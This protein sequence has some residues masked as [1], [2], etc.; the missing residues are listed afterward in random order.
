MRSRNTSMSR[1][2]AAA[3]SLCCL[4]LTGTAHAAVSFLSGTT[5][6]TSATLS[7]PVAVASATQTITLKSTTAAYKVYV[8]SSSTA[9]KITAPATGACGIVSTSTVTVAANASCNFNVSYTPT[10]SAAASATITAYVSATTTGTATAQTPTLAL[11]GNS[12][13]IALRNG[14]TAIT[15]YAFPSVAAGSTSTLAVT[16]ANLSTTTALSGVTVTA[17]GTGFTQSSTCATTLAASGTCVSNIT[18]APSAA[19]AFTGTLTVAATNSA[20]STVSLTGTGSTPVPAW[21]TTNTLGTG[22]AMFM[23]GPPMR[24][25]TTTGVPGCNSPTGGFVHTTQGGD[26]CAFASANY[27][28]SYD[29]SQTGTAY[30]DYY[31]YQASAGAAYNKATDYFGYSVLAPYA[32]AN[33]AIVPV[34]IANSAAMLIRLGNQ[35]TPT[36]TNG[37]ANVFSVTVKNQAID[38]SWPAVN[39]AACSVDVVLL[40][41]ATGTANGPGIASFTGAYLGQASGTYVAALGL[42]DYSIPLSAFTCATNDSGTGAAT[43]I[44][45]LKATGVTQVAIAIVGSKNPKVVA[46]SVDAIS[47]GGISFQ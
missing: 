23:A 22:T 43:T 12:A 15:S 5:T 17:S 36:A 9:F 39:P 29:S 30:D 6:I 31:I 10:T 19:G 2:A 24:Y 25:A 4:V 35:V 7:A 34:G 13:V 27:A 14:A 20:S 33:K 46:T 38:G 37:T 21:E 42:L 18:F 45:A 16:V 26:I 41:P 8:L 44:A 1:V 11:A 40:T 28:F 32:N 3:M 47:V